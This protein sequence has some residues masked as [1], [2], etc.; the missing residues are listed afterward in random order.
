MDLVH[1]LGLRSGF[2]G[3]W[4]EVLEVEGLGVVGFH[5]RFFSSFAVIFSSSAPIRVG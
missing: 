4:V 3:D 2:V 5:G 1:F